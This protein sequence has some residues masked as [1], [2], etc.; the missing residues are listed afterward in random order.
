MAISAYMGKSGT[1]D[2]A[3]AAFAE[4]YAAQNLEDFARFEAAIESGRLE[5]AEQV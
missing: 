1:L 4:T 5:V 3:V 2:R